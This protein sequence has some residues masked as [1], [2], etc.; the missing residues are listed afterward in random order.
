[1]I[2]FDKNI[3]MCYVL[4]KLKAPLE[5]YRADHQTEMANPTLNVL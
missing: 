2:Q 5:S 4:N 3:E 1:M